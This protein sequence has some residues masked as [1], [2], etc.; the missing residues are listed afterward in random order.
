MIGDNPRLLKI[1]DLVAKQS[2]WSKPLPPGQGRGIALIHDLEAVI[3]QVATVSI[4]PKGKLKIIK[5]DCVLDLGNYVNP[6][7]VKSQIEGGIV[8]GISSALKEKIIFEKGKVSQSNFDDYKI[9]KMK[10]IPEIEINLIKSDA[11]TKGVDMGVF[12]VAPAIT[13]AIFA[14]TGKRIRHL[15]IGKQK[16]V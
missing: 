4:S 2:N 14:A 1:L 8:M 13:N 15:P 10:D 12:P 5:I 6:S 7:I 11:N 9:A 3:A 16:L